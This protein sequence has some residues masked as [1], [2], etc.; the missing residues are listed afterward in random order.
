MK[1]TLRLSELLIA[2]VLLLTSCQ[3]DDGV[4]GNGNQ[5]E[6]IPDSFTSYFGNAISRDFLG[7]VIDKNDNPIWG[8][9]IT[10]GN[11]TTETDV[12]GVFILR[13]A[14]VYERFGYIK[15]EKAGYIHGSRSVVPSNGTNKVTIMLLEET[16]IGTVSSGSSDTVTVDDGSS[17]SFDGNFVKED[18]TAYTG[19]VNVIMHHLD[20]TDE[21]MEA[22]MPGMLYAQ[23]EDGAERMLQTFGMLAVKLRGSSGEDLNLAEGSTSEIKIPVDATLLASAPATIPL[24]YFDEE[25]GYWKEEGQATLQGNMYVGTVSH[26]SY[27]NFDVQGGMVTL[28][29]TVTDPE[30]NPLSDINLA[31]NSQSFGTENSYTNELGEACGLTPI[32]DILTVDVISSSTCGSTIIYTENIGSIATDTSITIVIDDNN[33]IIQDTVLGT[34]NTCDDTPVIDGYV[35][36][37]YGEETYIDIVTD[38]IFEI[39]LLRCSSDDTF[40][41]KGVDYTNLQTTDDISFT[42]TTPIT[43]IGMLLACSSVEEF[44]QITINDGDPKFD[45][46]DIT[47]TFTEIPNNIYPVTHMLQI[48]GGSD[49]LEGISYNLK[50]WSIAPDFVGTYYVDD[51]SFTGGPWGNP[52]V[53]AITLLNFNVLGEVGEYVD[54]SFN[55]FITSD[56]GVQPMSCIMHVIRDE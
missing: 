7:K 40:S 46:D 2:L 18:G 17:V 35:E 30:G 12:N 16:V 41:I 49:G 34:F 27:W 3:V 11:Q 31:I 14:N 42:F 52:Q 39:N 13:D 19:S 37:T 55:G 8:V 1:S 5:N 38:G 56:N 47:V 45:F 54:L 53:G 50:V 25:T 32:N 4:S 22:Q 15:A 28:C 10:I 6:N 33:D 9:T 48:N 29:I 36:L 20:P 51:T 21:D 23:N 44:V 26:F 24:W 43:D